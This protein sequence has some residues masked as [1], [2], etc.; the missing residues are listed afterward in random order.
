MDNAA[1]VLIKFSD[2]D[3]TTDDSRA[4]RRADQSNA[5]ATAIT[6]L[7]PFEAIDVIDS[8]MDDLLTE[9]LPKIENHEPSEGE[10]Q[11]FLTVR[12]ASRMS[13][14]IA[15]EVGAFTRSSEQ[16]QVFP[17]A[18]RRPSQAPLSLS[19]IPASPSPTLMQASRRSRLASSPPRQ[20][21][22]GTD[23]AGGE[24]PSTS[25]LSFVP[26]DM[27]DS[28]LADPA[29]WQEEVRAGVDSIA[30]R[31]LASQ[32]QG[33]RNAPGYLALFE[34]IMALRGACEAIDVARAP[35]SR[36]VDFQASRLV[37]MWQKLA[38]DADEYERLQ[39]S[40]RRWGEEIRSR[41]GPPT[42][43]ALEWRKSRRQQGELLPRI[44]Q[45]ENI[46]YLAVSLE[47]VAGKL[48][49]W[50]NVQAASAPLREQPVLTSAEIETEGGGRDCITQ[51]L[52]QSR[53]RAGEAERS[54][55]D[56][57]DES[58]KLSCHWIRVAAGAFLEKHK[59]TS[60]EESDR[61]TAHES[62]VINHAS[63]AAH[64][65]VEAVIATRRGP[66]PASNAFDASWMLKRAEKAL[67]S[68]I[69]CDGWSEDADSRK[70]LQDAL[71][72]LT[73]SQSLSDSDAKD[74]EI[75]EAALKIAELAEQSVRCLYATDGEPR[76]QAARKQMKA[77]AK[78]LKRKQA[79]SGLDD[80]VGEHI[81]SAAQLVHAAA[82]DFQLKIQA[83]RWAMRE[84]SAICPSDKRYLE[85][86]SAG[87]W[88]VRLD[89]VREVEY[90]AAA[91]ERALAANV[92]D[93][94][95]AAHETMPSIRAAKKSMKETGVPDGSTA[96]K[97]GVQLAL[98]QMDSTSAAQDRV[99][100]AAAARISA[101]Y[102]YD[103]YFGP[104]NEKLL[105]EKALMLTV[106]AADRP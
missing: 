8:W 25:A 20:S 66:G 60:D 46:A 86:R 11:L 3:N 102:L 52:Q 54:S 29:A 100:G 98:T 31:L 17:N 13:K 56:L 87:G 105:P 14:F 22:T 61:I 26:L 57:N 35:N 96:L 90:A 7:R 50:K 70:K 91:V 68:A 82:K 15:E 69:G 4:F 73:L 42:G 93:P 59:T 84:P 94:A 47:F 27:N 49:D 5:K 72:G 24:A 19:T 23:E 12:I 55:K 44:T 1:R 106:G 51:S 38:A 65:A 88:N 10:K 30:L 76:L 75:V 33:D 95:G 92:G 62:E 18:F 53:V 78:A 64:W 79:I 63:R 2:S 48:D 83:D 21:S 74:D 104:E 97:R 58:L 71:G 40:A 36:R 9:D 99:A 43:D 32:N 34:A 16:V 77:I 37:T 81:R 101:A 45:L 67:R 28:R 80:M 39:A 85:Y 6:A 41:V 103:A 89:D